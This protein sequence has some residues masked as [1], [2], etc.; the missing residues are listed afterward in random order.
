[1][2]SAG[3]VRKID[4]L[5]RVVLPMELRNTLC[6]PEG[7]PMEFFVNNDQIIIKKYEPGCVLC[8]SVEDVQPHKSGK[9]VCKA[10]L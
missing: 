7:T 1:M 4:T 2:K 9:L 10:C 8:G 3:I 5:G 6:L